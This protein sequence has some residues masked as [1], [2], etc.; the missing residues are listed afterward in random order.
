MINKRQAIDKNAHLKA[1]LI[2]IGAW[3][4]IAYIIFKNI[5]ELGGLPELINE[6]RNGGY[7]ELILLGFS[8]F[9]LAKFLQHFFNYLTFRENEQ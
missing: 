5:K 4:F 2:F 1:A 3:L 7:S 9:L 6:I 8:V